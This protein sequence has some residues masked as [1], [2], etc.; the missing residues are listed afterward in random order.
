MRDGAS[1][2]I[3]NRA[4]AP[5]VV[6]VAAVRVGGVK[7]EEAVRG[8][9]YLS[10]GGT[11][12]VECEGE[13]DGLAVIVFAADREEG[14]AG[15]V[16][17]FEGGDWVGGVGIHPGVA[18]AVR[19]SS[20]GV[21]SLRCRLPSNQYRPDQ[22]CDDNECGSPQTGTHKLQTTESHSCYWWIASM[23]YSRAAGAKTR[24]L[25]GLNC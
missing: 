23:R 24:E 18:G 10:V 13:V 3:R 14:A 2:A 4:W 9:A 17:P 20:I 6:E 5:V 16:N 11:E 7:A 8:D 15:G 25:V 12:E 21:A 19:P 1:Q 22:P